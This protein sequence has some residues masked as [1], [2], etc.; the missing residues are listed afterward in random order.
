M[1]IKF[2]FS[3]LYHEFILLYYSMVQFL[4]NIMVF[5]YA[6]HAK[7]TVTIIVIKISTMKFK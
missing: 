3:W 5:D 6:T 1:S 2:N 7:I 4:G